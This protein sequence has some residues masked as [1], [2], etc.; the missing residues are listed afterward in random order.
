LYSLLLISYRYAGLGLAHM[1]GKIKVWLAEISWLFVLVVTVIGVWLVASVTSHVSLFSLNV[2]SWLLVGNII[3]LY[4]L[5]AILWWVWETRKR[6]VIEKFSDYTKSQNDTTSPGNQATSPS[7]TT[8]PA[9][10]LAALLSVR[11]G[12]LRNL[13]RD[14][15]ER[16][17]ISSAVAGKGNESLDPTIKSDNN[18][19]SNFLSNAVTAQSKVNLG[20]FEIPVGTLLSFFGLLL[21]GPRII[22]G[23]HRDKDKVILEAR[24]IGGKQSY[25][26]R[27]EAP[28]VNYSLDG[29]VID[30]AYKIFIDLELEGAGSF[31]WQSIKTFIQG[32]EL[33]RNCLS[34]PR[35][36]KLN[37][38]QAEKKF[39]ETLTED[40]SFYLAYYNL[41]VVYTELAQQEK[42]NQN[43][44]ASLAY[45]KSAG[46]T[47][48]RAIELDPKAWRAYY[49]L[50][51]NRYASEDYE[52]VILLSDRVIALKPGATNVAKA[53]HMKGLAQRKRNMVNEAIKSHKR[54]VGQ[55]W[56]ALNRAELRSQAVARV[57]SSILQARALVSSCLRDLAI[58]Y[59]YQADTYSNQQEINQR[60]SHWFASWRMEVSFLQALIVTR[61]DADNYF[62]FGRVYA[63]WGKY[64]KAI[65]QY[66]SALRINPANINYW[67][68][69]ALAYARQQNE[70]TKSMKNSR[71]H[72]KLAAIVQKYE[73][74]A[75]D[76]IDKV[77]VCPSQSFDSDAFNVSVGV[78]AE[79]CIFDKI[80][81]F[82]NMKKFVELSR[83]ISESNRKDG[84]ILSLL[85]EIKPLPDSKDKQESIGILAL[86]QE[87]QKQYPA[88]T[89]EFAQV[90]LCLGDIYFQDSKYQEAET[91]YKN[92][93][94]NFEM[95]EIIQQFL[96]ARLA[97]S[98]LY[99]DKRK[100]EALQKAELAISLSPLK[101]YERDVLGQVHF[102]LNEFERAIDSWQKALLLNPNE[103]LFY[104]NIGISKVELIRNCRDITRKKAIFD[105]AFTH[106][107]HALELY[108]NNDQDQI[109]RTWYYLGI[110]SVEIG[111]YEDAIANLLISQQFDA[112][113]L[114]STFYL[115]ISYLINLDYDA[116]KEQFKRL[117]EEANKL[118]KDDDALKE[119]VEKLDYSLCE[120]LVIAYWG[121]ANICVKRDGELDNAMGFIMEGKKYVDKLDAFLQQGKA[122]TNYAD[123]KG[124][125]LDCKGWIL[126]KQ[127][128][129]DKIN[130]KKHPAKVEQP[131]ADLH[132][133]DKITMAIECLREAVSLTA[134]A[135]IYLHL[136]QI[137]D[138]MLQISEDETE[139]QHLIMLIQ[140]YC[141][142][143]SDLDINEQ[144]TSQVNDLQTHLT[145]KRPEPVASKVS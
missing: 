66:S 51:M 108:G 71:K 99:Q 79:L 7:N 49:A 84:E 88:K 73:K 25:S 103:P 31:Q 65:H 94:D 54:A 107:K 122:S 133:Q 74:G 21:Q 45:R 14:V 110:A 55:S 111:K 38:K 121:Q 134:D 35:D 46:N 75:N 96:Y 18:D 5:L 113:S 97:L 115:G 37:L 138:Y 125:Y 124:N 8:F 69:L 24:A 101:P 26:W 98:L 77:L 145:E 52:A 76:A 81:R 33:Y 23:L 78:S 140:A 137:Y 91:W 132:K 17:A 58:A 12:Y 10:G 92:A 128:Q 129:Q 68:Y 135:E 61:I 64:N 72:Q 27:V 39:F 105:E 118:D 40:E 142:H 104:Y 106:L 4:A 109:A 139:K 47:F 87:I 80:Q 11:L 3:A 43:D 44:E 50:M 117:Y 9:D 90:A 136:A 130:G 144:Y 6:L 131:A 116:S 86:L 13:Y 112:I 93:I 85:N 19:M 48:S 82:Y 20:P 56:K 143:V 95:Q 59:S 42:D 102:G 15:D 100:N 16:R 62:E 141:Q 1:L 53:C 70:L 119:I 22:G 67:A 57:N 29:M 120:L 83:K 36:R 28:S 34:T 123:C 63:D 126:F 60:M 2:W 127:G 114:H 41:G 32:L 30:L 89:W